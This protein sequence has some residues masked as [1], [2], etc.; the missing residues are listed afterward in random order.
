MAFEGTGGSIKTVG[1][2]GGITGNKLDVGVIDD[3][4]KN[5]ME[6]NSK[7][8]RDRVWGEYQDSFLTRLHNDSRQLLLFTRWHE[9]DLAGRILDPSNPHYDE[10]E[11]A[12]WTVIAL[13]A[14][15]EATPPLD[16]AIKVKDPRQIGEAL[17]EERHSRE[18]YE[19][20][21]RINPVGFCIA[22]PTKAM[23]R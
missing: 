21:K 19:K 22:R 7:T 2:I 11:A 5:R 18:K 13:P 17:W 20:R 10:K 6:A 3:P 12:E 1:M 16:C 15:K 14:L 9:D 4:F 23:H 8:I